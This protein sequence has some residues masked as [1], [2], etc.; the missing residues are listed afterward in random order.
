[1]KKDRRL[2]SLSGRRFPLGQIDI[3]KR[4]IVIRRSYYLLCTVVDFTD[5]VV[6]RTTSSP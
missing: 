5:C 1:M 6:T 3:G 4:Y 2:V